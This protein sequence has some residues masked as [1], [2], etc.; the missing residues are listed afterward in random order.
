M[1]IHC[2]GGAAEVG[3]SFIVVE[4][5]GLRV[6]VDCGIRLR[7]DPLPDLAR[8]G[9]IGPLDAVIV[10]HGHLDHIGALPLLHRSAPGVPIFATPPTIEIARVMLR[11]ALKIMEEGAEREGEIPLYPRD[12][13]E[14]LLERMIPIPPEQT[15]AIGSG[16]VRA[17]LFPA[18]HILGAASAG[19]ESEEGRVFVSGDISTA[20]Q[21]TVPGMS[22][23]RFRPHLAV[24]ESTYGDRLHANRDAEET[25]LVAMV[26]GAVG[27]GGKVLIPA[28]AIGRAQEV[29]LCLKRAMRRGAIPRFPVHVDGLVRA[30]CSLYGRRHG[31][32]L[33]EPLR[34]SIERHGDPFF[35][36]I[37]EIAPV[38]DPRAREAILAGPPCA[39]IASSGMLSGGASAFYARR[40]AEDPRAVIALTGYQDE[41]S[42]GRRL[43]EAGAGDTIPIAGD[44][45]P[46]RARVERYAL[47]AHADGD[48]I[49]GLV[50]A[51]RPRE[52]VL[53]H[54]DEGA[55]RSLAAR[56]RAMRIPQCYLPANGDVLAFHFGR[57]FRPIQREIA[58][59]EVDLDE[60]GAVRL[61]DALLARHGPRETFRAEEIARA[62][63]RS[64]EEVEPWLESSPRF[65]RDRK[66]TFL[67]RAVPAAEAP[68]DAGSVE[69]NEILRR[70]AEAFGPETGLYRRGARTEERV[71]ILSFA[72]P[73]IA[74]ARHAAALD[75]LLEGTGWTWEIN[76]T[77]HAG[78]LAAAVEDLLP[79][80]VTLARPPAIHL[81]RS[82]VVATLSAPTDPAAAAD[83]SARFRE[84]TGFDLS[85]REDPGLTL[86]RATVPAAGGPF[87]I[88]AAF[89]RIEEAFAGLPHR[90]YRKSRKPGPDGP[91]IELSFI[92]PEVGERYREAIESVAAEIGWRIRVAPSP[93]QIEICERARRLVAGETRIL[94]GPSFLRSE[95]AVR[96]VVDRLPAEDERGALEEA[97]EAETGYRLDLR[98]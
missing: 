26:A 75:R 57:G 73:S 39:I 84:R 66:R 19:L 36:D 60:D 23:P 3:A 67:W 53:V 30:I 24:V 48:A 43:L 1:R 98:A 62:A 4:T 33:R 93:N 85:F 55:R 12:A 56:I 89:R 25:R 94:K 50:S 28:F 27:A 11:D 97:F 51:L 41:E 29:I 87:E 40:L 76:A 14:S 92:S 42:P 88:N 95:R 79:A 16:A 5:G 49:A 52:V 35:G 65:D 61:A 37:D 54:G 72:F 6:A 8:I 71:V 17:T 10:T 9:E 15:F 81:D 13:V 47:S 18:G 96:V 38:P 83:L 2:L 91:F 46:L 58:S 44:A 34:R 74:G 59:I 31:R 90:P 20:H 70:V 86:P 80:G 78:A 69:Q 68:P 45:V 82:E 77:P 64:P 21:L 63:G 22:V 7:G 32:Y